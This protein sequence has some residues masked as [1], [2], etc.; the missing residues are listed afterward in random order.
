MEIGRARVQPD[1]QPLPPT[2]TLDVRP[3]PL[4]HAI[5]H[6][7]T[8]DNV[9]ILSSRLDADDLDKNAVVLLMLR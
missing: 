2:D 6:N 4:L 9:S 3:G 8:I 7:I 5:K 1:P